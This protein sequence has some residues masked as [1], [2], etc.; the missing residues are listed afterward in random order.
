MVYDWLLETRSRATYHSSGS[1][2]KGQLLDLPV[3]ESV[4][5]RLLIIFPKW[6]IHSVWWPRLVVCFL[7]Y[8]LN[9]DSLIHSISLCPFCIFNLS[10]LRPFFSVVWNF[11]IFISRDVPAINLL[12]HVE[13]SATLSGVSFQWSHIGVHL[14]FQQQC[15]VTHAKCCWPRMFTWALLLWRFFG[16]RV[17]P[18]WLTLAALTAPTPPSPFPPPSRNRYSP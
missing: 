12:V 9:I 8:N 13:T 16:G 1:C 17:M 4:L 11:G 7:K 3:K 18:L 2:V 15:V 5:Q 14:I 10:I 6:C